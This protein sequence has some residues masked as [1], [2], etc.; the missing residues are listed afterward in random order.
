[1]PFAQK[2]LIRKAEGEF[3]RENGGGSTTIGVKD[4]KGY[5]GKG[6]Q[7]DTLILF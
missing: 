1:M 4:V 5:G 2:L 6:N 7:N 3:Q